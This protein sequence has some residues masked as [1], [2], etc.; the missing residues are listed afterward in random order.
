[1]EKDCNAPV[2]QV[3]AAAAMISSAA[4]SRLGPPEA[5]GLEQMR[6]SAKWFAEFTRCEEGDDDG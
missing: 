4:A 5:D 1:M 3:A 6:A 2:D